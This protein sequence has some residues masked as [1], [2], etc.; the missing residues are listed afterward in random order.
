MQEKRYWVYQDN[1]Y[2]PL[3][4]L[5][6]TMIKTYVKHTWR[7]AKKELVIHTIHQL[8]RCVLY[9]IDHQGELFLKCEWECTM[10]KRWY[11]KTDM[12]V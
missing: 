1:T 12:I 11:S 4:I 5:L 9:I 2:K 6:K 8:P 7:S 3:I 10:M